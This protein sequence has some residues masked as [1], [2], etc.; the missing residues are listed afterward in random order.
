MRTLGAIVLSGGLISCFCLTG[1]ARG[2]CA[3]DTIG[4]PLESAN[5]S[6]APILGEAVG[7]TFYATDTLITKVTVWRPPDNRS[8]IGAH[9]FITAVD[10]TLNPPR[11]DT[12]TILLDGP[13]VRVVDSTPPGGFIEMP[14][15]IDPPLALPRPGYYAWFLQAE[16]CNQGEA[17]IIVSNDSNPYPWG[18]YW[19]TN[20]VATCFLAN[21]V[22]GA[23]N[24]DMIFRMEFCG[25][26]STPTRSGTWGDLKL[27]YR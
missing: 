13:T 8:V 7:Q 23:D 14:F 16:D 17:W 27:I 20:R 3:P 26:R 24:V 5:T 2:S 11:P 25:S 15:V 6:G 18:I 22:G 10:T 21:V 12:H 4:I 9:L 1:T 19:L